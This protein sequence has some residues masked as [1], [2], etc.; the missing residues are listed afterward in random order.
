MLRGIGRLKPILMVVQARDDVARCVMMD[1]SPQA[2]KVR[3]ECE[4]ADDG[5]SVTWSFSTK[6]GAYNK[7]AIA[8]NFTRKRRVFETEVDLL[9]NSFAEAF[10]QFSEKV[11]VFIGKM[12]EMEKQGVQRPDGD[13]NGR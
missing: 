7:H 11:P 5:T 8:L 4:V 2:D 12:G 13:G 3:I 1:G 6:S 10:E 9:R